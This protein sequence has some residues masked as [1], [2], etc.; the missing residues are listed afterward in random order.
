MDVNKN[1]YTFLFAAIMVV[2]VA[3]IL[4][5]TATS[6]QS[7]QAENVRKEKMQ[8]ILASINVEVSRDEADK[9]YQK[10]ITEERI[11]QG[12]EVVEGEKAFNVRMEKQVAIPNDQRKAPLYIAEKD[13]KTYYVLPLRG[14][15]LWGPIWGYIS[16]KSDAKEVY[17]ATFDHASETPGL[18][19]EISTDEFQ[20][21][22]NNK[23]I[24]DESGQFTGIQVTKKD[25]QGPRQVDGISG[26]TITSVG[27]E[28]MIQDCVA[29]YMG[30]LKDFRSQVAS[31]EEKN[32]DS[33]LA[34]AE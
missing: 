7:R 29:A 15:G 30:Y 17:G 8:S 19:A 5:F 4:S 33:K 23:R 25:A 6:L 3:A 18:G 24:L 31:T 2:V 22:F 9:A 12:G 20:K 28:D 32:L 16:L 11:I 14:K 13:G 10:Y 21:Q 26:G 34:N 1:S 27:V